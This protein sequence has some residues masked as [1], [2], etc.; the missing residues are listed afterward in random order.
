MATKDVIGEAS[1][2]LFG[3]IDKAWGEPMTLLEIG[4][5][6]NRI[7]DMLVKGMGKEVRDWWDSLQ[8]QYRSWLRRRIWER[9]LKMMAIRRRVKL[10]K[11]G[12]QHHL[13]EAMEYDAG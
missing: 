12:Y 9:T 1:R 6:N 5:E 10:K 8:V 3:I 4:R 11:H 13:K 7:I 2:D